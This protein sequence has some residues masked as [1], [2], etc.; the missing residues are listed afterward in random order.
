MLRLGDRE[1]VRLLAG[2]F[3]LA[4]GLSLTMGSAPHSAASDYRLKVLHRFCPRDKP[5]CSGGEMPSSGLI[6]DAEGNLYGTTS[7]GGTGRL[8]D[9][10]G[11]RGCGTVFELTRDNSRPSGRGE[12]VLYHFCREGALCPDG[13]Q[14]NG[15]LIINAAGNLYGTTMRVATWTRSPL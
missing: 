6:M 13:N 9:P 4:A 3:A 5:A 14:P 2:I 12:T 8:C 15:G 1:R 7:A 11:A 10:F